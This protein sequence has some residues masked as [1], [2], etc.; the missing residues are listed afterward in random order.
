MRENLR[1]TSYANGTYIEPQEKLDGTA[2]YFNTG[3][4]YFYNGEALEAG[5]IS[6]EGWQLPTA[7][8]WQTLNKYVNK[9]ASLLKGGE[10]RILSSDPNSEIGNP[11]SNLTMFSIL[12][13]GQW[14][15][16][17]GHVN[18]NQ[19]AGFWTWDYET[20]SIAKE[21]IFFSGQSDE[22]QIAS[23]QASGQNFSKALSV[24]C[25]KRE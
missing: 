7:K 9:D 4:I 24:R 14:S 20:D 13:L 25:L 10:W 19:A 6:P 16:S 5:E 18:L 22:M 23:T 11:V 2:G 1:A 12:P 17:G 3:D 8:D 15:H 21:T